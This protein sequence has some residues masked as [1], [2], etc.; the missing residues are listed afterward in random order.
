[1]KYVLFIVAIFIMSCN[2]KKYILIP[3]I[4]GKVYSKITNAPIVGV[5]IYGYKYSINNFDTIRTSSDGSFL[6]S[7]WSEKG[8]ANFRK[9]SNDIS[10]TFFLK[11]GTITKL[12][13][14]KEFYGKF[15]YF[16]KDTIDIGL[17]YLEDLKSINI[18]LAY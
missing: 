10:H 8:Y 16:Q 2:N 18:N 5:K 4:K 1:M 7:G 3:S 11:S 13:D 14:A 9:Y 12:I 6:V 15:D 17:F